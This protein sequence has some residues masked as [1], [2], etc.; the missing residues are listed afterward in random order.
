MKEGVLCPLVELASKAVIEYQLWGSK[1]G[2]CGLWWLLRHI[3]PFTHAQ[4]NITRCYTLLY[5]VQLQTQPAANVFPA[6]S[7]L[8][9]VLKVLRPALFDAGPKTTTV[10]AEKLP[11]HTRWQ[12]G[13][14]AN[15]YRVSYDCVGCSNDAL[16]LFRFGA[17]PKAHNTARL[18]AYCLGDR[19]RARHA[20][21]RY[22][23]CWLGLTPTEENEQEEGN[24]SEQEETEGGEGWRVRGAS[25]RRVRWSAS[26]RR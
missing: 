3:H 22:C 8:V 18:V 14:D 20:A 21:R 4:S 12:G 19:E 17:T 15:T 13:R 23:T 9:A 6:I 10:V 1:P 5:V 2:A 25:R 24:E 26:R 11:P 7:H 16:A